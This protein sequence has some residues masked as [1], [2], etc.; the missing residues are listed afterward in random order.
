MSLRILLDTWERA[1]FLSGDLLLA[2]AIAD[3]AD[4][5]GAVRVDLNQIAE[6][7]G[8]S[9]SSI[10]TRLSRLRTAGWIAPTQPS[11]GLLP[12]DYQISRSWLEGAD[13][14]LQEEMP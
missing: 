11:R 5:R 12:R 14:P 7:A 6:R 4:H 8:A 9:I 3:T 1:P 13:L 10:R 2:M